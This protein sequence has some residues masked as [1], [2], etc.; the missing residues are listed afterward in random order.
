MCTAGI[1]SYLKAR[2]RMK[3][4]EGDF[5]VYFYIPTVDN[6]C[7]SIRIS[8][9]VAHNGRVTHPY[10]SARI[11]YPHIISAFLHCASFIAD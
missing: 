8:I 1:C 6:V 11:H 5:N 4:S 10:W 2:A 3:L 9:K 7:I